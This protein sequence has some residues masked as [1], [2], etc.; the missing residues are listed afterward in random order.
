MIET[1]TAAIPTADQIATFNRAMEAKETLAADEATRRW[2]LV[3]NSSI[4]AL[5]TAHRPG[6]ALTNREKKQFWRDLRNL[7]RLAQLIPNEIQL[8]TA[9]GNIE[10]Q[11]LRTQIFMQIAPWLRFTLSPE[12]RETYLEF[13]KSQ[14]RIESPTVTESIAIEGN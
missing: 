9:L 5:K 4:L 12:I 14:Q 8:V 7:K 6:T 2:V 13:Y 11:W 1:T 10:N 3:F